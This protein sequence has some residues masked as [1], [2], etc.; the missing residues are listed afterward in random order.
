[1]RAVIQR[2]NFGRVTVEGQ[3]TGQIEQGLVVLLGV[4]KEDGAGDLEYLVDKVVNL[5]IF[6][7]DQGKMNLSLLDVGGQLLAVSQFTLLGDC[8]KGRR[9]GFSEAAPPQVAKDYY[10][11]FIQKVRELGITVATGQFQADMLVEVH[12]AGPV[13]I[14]LDSKRLF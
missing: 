2:V 9:P 14:L 3:V 1:M 6:E 10:E 12:N 4:A 11:G 13:T 8:R 7:D 5:R